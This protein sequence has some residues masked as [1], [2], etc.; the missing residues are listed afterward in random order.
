MNTKNLILSA[1]P[2]SCLISFTLVTSGQDTAWE[3]VSL[4]KEVSINMPA[5]IQ[6]L[7]TL[8]LKVTSSTS[9]GYWF[10]TKLIKQPLTVRNGDELVQAY[11]SFVHGYLT[12]KGVSI[13]TNVVSDTSLGV[14]EGK[15]I[16]STY[17]Q[18]GNFS[19][20]F[21]YAVLVNSHFYTIT[22][23]SDHPIQANG[24][25][26]LSKYIGSLSF[27]QATIREYSDDF[28]LR[29][30]SYRFGER[31]GRY[32]IY[33]VFLFVAGLVIYFVVNKLSKTKNRM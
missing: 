1:F 8:Q 3:K 12:S 17:A 28:R 25:L 9:G 32:V 30:H 21:T 7:N 16:H 14:T 29:S 15:W 20:M 24:R 13:Y 5:P 31:L 23:F 33:F 4:S 27:S 11:E 6:Y 10:Q 22:F 26:L 18:N 19:E 2:S